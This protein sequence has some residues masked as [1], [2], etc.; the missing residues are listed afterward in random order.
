M[1][2]QP[3]KCDTDSWIALKKFFDSFETA[4]AASS[5]IVESNSLWLRD[6]FVVKKS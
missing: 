3:E 6:F 5:L 4:S 1:I 2:R